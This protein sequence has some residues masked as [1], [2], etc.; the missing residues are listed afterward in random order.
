MIF[1]GTKVVLGDHMKKMIVI[2][3]FSLIAIP[4]VQA[5]LGMLRN[6]PMK[7]KIHKIV[8]VGEGIA[9][10]PDNL[11]EFSLIRTVVGRVYVIVLNK[12]LKVSR[13]LL[14]VDGEKYI[15]KNITVS[16]DNSVVAEIYQNRSKV[17]SLKAYPVLKGKRV[18]WVGEMFIDSKILK[19]YIV[20]TP[21]TFRPVEIKE[22]V[23]EYCE[24]HP[25]KCKGIGLT[26]CESL[27]DTSCRE[28]IIEWCKEHQDDV[29]CRALALRAKEILPNVP[30]MPKLEEFK[31]RIRERLK[32]NKYCIDN[33]ESCT[34]IPIVQ[35][36]RE[37]LH[38]VGG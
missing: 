7:V 1:R 30:K 25:S 32:T 6:P 17:G 19:I 28:K 38:T 10:N 16:T 2:A 23:K 13:G 24:E 8:I 3:L 21:R 9:V 29:R 31:E 4:L 27:N 5:Q 35:K 20:E 18:V 22:K 36:I 37:R 11:D 15:L 14:F 12:T 33:P 34:Q 26:G